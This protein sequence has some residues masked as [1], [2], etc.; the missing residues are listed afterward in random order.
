MNV[1]ALLKRFFQRI[2][3]GNLVIQIAI[4]IAIGIV[5]SLIG[6]K[7]GSLISDG[8]FPAIVS[9]S[10]LLGDLFIR[11]LRSIAPI[12]VFILVMSS[13]I[14]YKKVD[15]PGIGAILILY[16]IGTFSAALIAVA[17][18]FLFPSTLTLGLPEEGI[19]PPSGIA[20]VLKN[21]L[22]DVIMNPVEALMKPSYLGILIWAVGFGVILRNG[23]ESTKAVVSDFSDAVIA[24]VQLVVRFAPLGVFGLIMATLATPDG[25]E[26][27]REYA[28]LL[29]VLLGCMLTV[30]L[31]LNPAIV[32]WKIRRNPY[33]LIWTCL[34][35]SGVTAFMMRSS[36]ANIPV[37]L[38]LCEKLKL[39]REIYSITIPLGAALNMAGAAV[40]ITLLTLAA[41]HSIPG[42]QID[43]WSALLLSVLA[44]VCACG[45]SGVAGGSLLLIPLACSMFGISNEVAM[46]VVG[47]GFI[48]GVL[49]DSAETAVNSST[50]VMFTAAVC[51]ANEQADLKKT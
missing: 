16:A 45:A 49:Q 18:G 4:G 23:A 6:P 13:I 39:D 44:S 26:K 21:V 33:P 9:F 3:K 11:A 2:A 5:V 20:E 24:I 40:T 41:V 35:E 31:V 30:A 15:K 36:A 7:V 12:L 43:F 27:L 50:D 25:F 42:M 14:N 51:M 19:T 28:H 34:R 22:F 46:Q 10:T 47:V 48:I 37:N 1:L 29:G 38:N 17:A 8:F 32:Y